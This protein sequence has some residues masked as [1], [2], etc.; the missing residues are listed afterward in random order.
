MVI[1]LLSLPIK[2]CDNE[3]ALSILLNKSLSSTPNLNF[4]FIFVF[5]PKIGFIHETA[6]V[7]I[8]TKFR[9]VDCKMSF[10]DHNFHISKMTRVSWGIRKIGSFAIT[11]KHLTRC[12][13]SSGCDQTRFYWTQKLYQRMIGLPKVACGMNYLNCVRDFWKLRRSQIKYQI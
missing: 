1:K 3:I 6:F 12:F 5:I 13:S 10:N 4:I 7:L 2:K 9:G 8:A 11:Q